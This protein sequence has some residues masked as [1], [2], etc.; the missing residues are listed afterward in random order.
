SGACSLARQATRT[1]RTPRLPKAR[2]WRF[3]TMATLL[4]LERHFNALAC[5]RHRRAGDGSGEIP[6]RGSQGEKRADQQVDG[7]GGITALH[8]R[9]ARLAR[10]EQLR[11]LRLA[12]L[13]LLPAKPQAVRQP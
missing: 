4:L 7:N 11:E 3:R 10:T 9:D 5:F 8:L 12:Q 6:I 13:P 2:L 1:A